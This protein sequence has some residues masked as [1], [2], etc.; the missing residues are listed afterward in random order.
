MV[1]AFV[2]LLSKV[3]ERLAKMEGGLS[4]EWCHSRYRTLVC[5]SAVS[6]NINTL[7]LCSS[8]LLLPYSQNPSRPRSQRV[9]DPALTFHADQTAVTWAAGPLD[10]WAA[11]LL[12]CWT[13]GLPACWLAGLLA[14]RLAGAGAAARGASLCRPAFPCRPPQHLRTI[15]GKPFSHRLHQRYRGSLRDCVIRFR[16]RRGHS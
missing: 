13:A 12:G 2:A 16:L 7:F 1:S 6:A 9:P 14:W 10:C 8:P 4:G 5:I 15:S 11:G 3:E